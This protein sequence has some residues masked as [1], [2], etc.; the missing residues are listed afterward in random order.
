MI[1]ELRCT[2]GHLVGVEH[3]TPFGVRTVLKQRKR[4][5]WVGLVYLVWCDC[6]AV[7]QRE[8]RLPLDGLEHKAPTLAGRR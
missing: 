2:D 3:D 1:R 8:P 7:W 4:V 6:G 5:S